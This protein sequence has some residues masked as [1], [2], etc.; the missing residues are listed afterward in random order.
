MLERK[1]GGAS[2]KRALRETKSG[3]IGSYV[4]SNGRMAALV[5]VSCE[6]DFVA[7]N[8]GF[9]E[10]AHDLAMH[11]AA[12]KPVFMSVKD[13]PPEEWQTEKT[14]FMEEAQKM[15]KPKSRH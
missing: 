13:V 7:R 15:N 5:E 6:T 12:M 9:G 4:H 2:I 8:P 11:V 1:L 14:R 3:I 10:L